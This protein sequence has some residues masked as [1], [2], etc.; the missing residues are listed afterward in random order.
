MTR[1]NPQMLRSLRSPYDESPEPVT[2][3]SRNDTDYLSLTEMARYQDS[4]RTDYII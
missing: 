1:P 4:E 3:I 2:A